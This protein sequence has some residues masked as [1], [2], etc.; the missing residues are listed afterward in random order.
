VNMATVPPEAPTIAT[1]DIERLISVDEVAGRLGVTRN[2]IYD[3][4]GKGEFPRPSF[5]LGRLPRWRVAQFNEWVVERARREVLDRAAEEAK[6][7]GKRKPR[8]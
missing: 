7:Q 1:D 5:Y 4:M 2:A 6:K 8:T 3:W